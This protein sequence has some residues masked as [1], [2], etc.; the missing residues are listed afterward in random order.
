VF[1][2]WSSIST[3]GPFEYYMLTS[4]IPFRGLNDCRK[5]L[6]LMISHSKPSETN[7]SAICTQ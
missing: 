2:T 3:Q 7:A 6:F 1:P 4:K 5:V